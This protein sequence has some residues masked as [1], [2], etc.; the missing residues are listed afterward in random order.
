MLASRAAAAASAARTAAMQVQPTDCSREQQ[1][2]RCADAIE[3]EAWRSGGGGVEVELCRPTSEWASE[4]RWRNHEQ[5]KGEEPA[6]DEE[7]LVGPDDGTQSDDTMVVRGDPAELKWHYNLRQQQHQQQQLLHQQ[8]LPQ[9]HESRG[10]T[11]VIHHLAPSS[12]HQQDILEQARII[13]TQLVVE[14][15][16]HRQEELK[17]QQQQQ[18]WFDVQEPQQQQSQRQQQL[19]QQRQQELQQPLLHQQLKQQQQNEPRFELSA[20]HHLS[21]ASQQQWHVEHQEHAHRAD[22]ALQLS[23]ASNASGSNASSA[24]SMVVNVH[25]APHA[26]EGSAGAAGSVSEVAATQWECGE[27]QPE[28]NGSRQD[29]AEAAVEDVSAAV[30]SCGVCLAATAAAI[31]HTRSLMRLLQLED[32]GHRRWP[33]P[34]LQGGA[35]NLLEVPTRAS[36]EN[37]NWLYSTHSSL[38][39]FNP[40]RFFLPDCTFSATRPR[41]G[42]GMS[43]QPAAHG[44]RC[45]AKQQQAVQDR[46]RARSGGCSRRGEA[47]GARGGEN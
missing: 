35:T 40:T 22:G 18:Q 21:P 24:C 32:D 1:P 30:A 26:V 34:Q 41:V 44:P 27:F 46:Q 19:Q 2:L 23:G 20:I 36:L 3:A 37:A 7:E 28:G 29:G 10:E 8:L 9:Q 14:Q 11:R 5:W 47:A 6:E 13:E 42:G 12:Q 15:Q 25:P 38:A 33:Q 31:A 4:M 45:A 39:L 43:R 17:Q 16:Q